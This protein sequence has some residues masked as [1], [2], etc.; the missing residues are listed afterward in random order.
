MFNFN[1]S[2]LDRKATTLKTI[3]YFVL[4]NHLELFGNWNCYDRIGKN[5]SSNSLQL[6]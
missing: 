5:I 2:V 6:T 3:K 1:H 4:C